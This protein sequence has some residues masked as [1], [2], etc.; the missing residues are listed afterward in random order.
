MK[1]YLALV[2]QWL[3]SKMEVL[4]NKKADQF[5]TVLYE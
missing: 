5:H 2:S 4:E 3:S 1:A